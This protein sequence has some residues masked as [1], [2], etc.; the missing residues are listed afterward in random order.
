MLQFFSQENKD[1][2]TRSLYFVSEVNQYEVYGKLMNLNAD[3]RNT[4]Y[5]REVDTDFL[6]KFYEFIYQYACCYVPVKERNVESVF[7]LIRMS[8]PLGEADCVLVQ[9]LNEEYNQNKNSKRLSRIIPLLN[10]IKPKI[11]YKNIVD[12]MKVFY[13]CFL[14]E[15][16]YSTDYSETMLDI[17]DMVDETLKLIMSTSG[18]LSYER[19]LSELERQ[20]LESKQD[21]VKDIEVFLNNN[22]PKTICEYLDKYIVGQDDA[23]K[24]ISINVYYYLKRIANPDIKMTTNNNILMV[25]P[26]GCG[27][28]EIIR[29]LKNFLPIPVIIYD[30]SS[31]TS[32]GYKG[33]NKDNILRPLV[34]TDGVALVFLDE[35][36][37][38]CSPSIT[39]N[40]I[41]FSYETQG[42]LLSMIEGNTIP[43]DDGAAYVNTENTFFIAGGAFEN[44]KIASKKS[45]APKMIGFG[46]SQKEE[47]KQEPNDYKVAI[48]DVIKYGL[49]PELA[50]RFSSVITLYPLSDEQL[51]G[52]VTNYIS[53]FEKMINK[54]VT[55]D[56]NDLNSEIKTNVLGCRH[57]KQIINDILKDALFQAPEHPDSKEVK[58]EKTENGF[59]TSFTKARG[60]KKKAE[61]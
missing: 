24:Q 18:K 14:Y 12:A 53:Q 28:T 39:S 57:I 37:K 9:Y 46:N 38:I 56:K 33:D 54:K 21:F 2:D 34:D 10:E 8:V 47:K 19:P 20:E 7:E 17:H 52:I 5:Y 43:I 6:Y 59:I 50:G 3:F 40:G 42:Q 1:Q 31:L 36:D 32:S 35:F 51:H 44:M 45:D 27:K 23:K 26:S 49:R 13:F 61:V 16:V 30:V 29:T 58:I 48:T 25:G 4:V 55:V 22:T 15:S 11:T 60:R 41:N